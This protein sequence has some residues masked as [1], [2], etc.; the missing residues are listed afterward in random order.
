MSTLNASPGLATP[1]APQGVAHVPAR[2]SAPAPA[3]VLT[4]RRP[5]FSLR[6][7]VLLAVFGAPFLYFGYVILDQ[8]MTGGIT[9][10]GAYFDV[11]LKSLGYFPFDSVK[12]GI[13]DVPAKFRELDGKRVALVGEM[14]VTNSSSNDIKEF[15]LV[16]SI[17]KC[18]FGGPPKVQERVF[19]RAPNNGTV[20]YYPTLVR[21]VGTL[22][23]NLERDDVGNV[24]KLYQLD[25]ESLDPA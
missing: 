25:I 16:Y 23:V 1:A 11:D 17:Q 3:D 15:E 4:P 10:R 2:S 13:E 8:A 12:G 22:R 21:V 19:A 7:L 14:W 20:P 5:W 9:D 6:L 18:C 24:S